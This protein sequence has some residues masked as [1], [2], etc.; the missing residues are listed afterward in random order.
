MYRQHVDDCW[1]DQDIIAFTVGAYMANTLQHE[2]ADRPGAL[3]SAVG[4]TA[5]DYEDR[6]KLSSG[7][8]AEIKGVIGAT[9]EEVGHAWRHFALATDCDL[10]DLA[11]KL[12]LSRSTVSNYGAG[13]TQ[14]KC[15][16]DQAAVMSDECRSRI[17]F[18][19]QALEVFERI[20]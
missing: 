5:T 7:R 18:L 1:P 17:Q 16:L 14:A 20:K 3:L 10:G 6:C 4:F 12:G 11:K 15:T 19:Q 2:Y 13:K 8:E 9:K